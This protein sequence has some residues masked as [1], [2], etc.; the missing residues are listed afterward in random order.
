MLN[1]KKTQVHGRYPFSFNRETSTHAKARETYI[2]SVQLPFFK[3]TQ[4]AILPTPEVFLCTKGDVYREDTESYEWIHIVS[5]IQV[6]SRSRVTF[7]TSSYLNSTVRYVP[8]KKMWKFENKTRTHVTAVPYGSQPFHVSLL[9][10]IFGCGLTMQN[11]SFIV[12]KIQD[13]KILNI[14][15]KGNES[16][17]QDVTGDIH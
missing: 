8:G 4:I 1:W 7:V 14:D 12:S 6:P 9:F 15:L 5:N 16:T 17:T 3:H 10:S 11:G 13:K 2:R